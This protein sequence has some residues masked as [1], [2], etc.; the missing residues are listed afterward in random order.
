MTTSASKE[1]VREKPK[2][3]VQKYGGATVA[4][5]AKI[6]Q[7]AARLSELHTQGTQVVAVVS[8]MG[9]TTN[10][11]MELASQV[12]AH[13]NRREMDMLLTTGERVTMAL[14]SMA[15]HDQGVPAIS[16]TGSQAGIFTDESHVNAFIMDVKAH[17]V[18][19]AIQNK[20][21]VVLAGYQGVSPR[22]KEITTLG[23]GGTDTTAVAI[24]AYLGADRC[25][26]LKDVPAVFS[27]DPQLIPS[28]KI[29]QRLT[30][31]QMLEMTFWGAKVL[32]YRSVELAK[33]KKVPLYIGPAHHKTSEGTWISEAASEGKNMFESQQILALNSFEK[34]LKLQLECKSSAEGFQTLQKFFNEKEIPSPQIL[35]LKFADGQLQIYLTGPNEIVTA[36]KEELKNHATIK[37]DAQTF[38]SIAA[39][40]TGVTSPQI[41]EK[42]LHTL[43]ESAIEISDV[44]MTAM[45]AVVLLPSAQREKA[46]HQLHSLI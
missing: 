40:C 27:A 8:A 18:D 32:H 34:V 41:L 33:Q 5:P 42:I 17:R 21:V 9:K 15:L 23:R 19:E 29:L 13:P 14:L 1:K 43:K 2:L 6:K 12:S 31:D 28:A 25:E 16:F 26:I 44:W 46:L 35:S 20:K 3:I 11:L 7:V 45:S 36:I 22:T 37:M 24:A 4:D 38:S 39:T 10:Q 30:Y